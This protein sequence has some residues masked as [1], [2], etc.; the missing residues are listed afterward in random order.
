MSTGAG[1]SYQ[2]I[3]L[4]RRLFR[5]L[6]QKSNES[7]QKFGVTAADRAVLEFL[8]PDEELSV[9]D[10]A[11]RYQVSRQHV[12]VTVNSLVDGNLLIAKDNPRHKRSPLISLTAKGRNLFSRIKK[13][14]LE[15]VDELFSTISAK[16]RRTTQKTLNT[17]LAQLK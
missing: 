12:Q 11:A 13:Q 15:I 5:A 1:D 9:P 10:I 4:V 3:W 8:H 17:L 16:E 7:L 2:I 6:S 14:D